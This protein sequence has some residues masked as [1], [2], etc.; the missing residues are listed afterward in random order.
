MF[1]TTLLGAVSGRVYTQFVPDLEYQLL[2]T[3]LFAGA[4]SSFIALGVG[5]MFAIVFDGYIV[6]NFFAMLAIAISVSEAL[7]LWIMYQS[8]KNK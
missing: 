1:F 2:P 5:C 6:E 8:V 7:L 4:L 3:W